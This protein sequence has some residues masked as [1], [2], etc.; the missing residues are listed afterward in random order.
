MIYFIENPVNRAVKVG[1][2]ASPERR[3]RQLQKQTR[4]P[5]RLLH[6]HSGPIQLEHEIHKRLRGPMITMASGIVPRL[7]CSTGSVLRRSWRWLRRTGELK[8][9]GPT[10]ANRGASLTERAKQRCRRILATAT[11]QIKCCCALW[12]PS[13]RSRANL[14][15]RVSAA[16]GGPSLS[17][18]LRLTTPG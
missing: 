3:L 8:K 9:R 12:L 1:Y 18:A 7:G 13:A 5:L 2:S 4:D 16:E 6:A 17:Q 15:R 11:S 14:A 10:G